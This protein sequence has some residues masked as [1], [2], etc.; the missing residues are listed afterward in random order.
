[1]PASSIA[2]EGKPKRIMS[3]RDKPLAFETEFE[4]LRALTKHL[5]SYFGDYR[6]HG[7]KIEAS[8]AGDALFNLKPLVRQ[9]GKERRTSAKRVG[10]PRDGPLTKPK[11]FPLERL[12]PERLQ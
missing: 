8:S 10:V 3:E 11:I 9:R 5:L 7:A 1:L 6:R 2:A 4:A 12:P